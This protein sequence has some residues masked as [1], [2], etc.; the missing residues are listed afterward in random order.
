MLNLSAPFEHITDPFEIHVAQEVL[1]GG[2]VA[3]LY[4]H[5][6]ISDVRQFSRTDPADEKQYRM[7]LRYLARGGVR[8][9]ESTELDPQWRELVDQLLDDP[10]TSWLAKG[11]G[12][13]LHGLPLDIAVYTH[14]DGDFIGVHKDK[15]TKAITAIL[16]LNE[17]WPDAVGGQYEVRS[18]GDPQA[19]PVR[20]IAPRAGQVLAFPPTDRSWH[21]VSRIDGGPGLVRLTVQLEYWFPGQSSGY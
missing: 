10:F 15:P 7:N 17:Q 1:T 12:L 16:Y 2:Q 6:P 8:E 14:V 21:S 9:P 19:E 11:T 3:S 20:R 18:G 13:A 4:A 5:A